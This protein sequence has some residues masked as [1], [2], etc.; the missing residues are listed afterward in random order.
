[1]RFKEYVY[2]RFNVQQFEILRSGYHLA[3]VV[4]IRALI[5]L[6]CQ[7]AI[8]LQELK[9]RIPIGLRGNQATLYPLLIE[10]HQRPAH[11]VILACIYLLVHGLVMRQV[12][13]E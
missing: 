3:D 5:D 6:Q 1:M 4:A 7:P 2:I 11:I 10:H 12:F 13:L 8:I 9:T